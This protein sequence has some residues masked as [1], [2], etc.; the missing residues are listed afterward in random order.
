[1]NYLRMTIREF[2]EEFQVF[3]LKRQR[4]GGFATDMAAA[5]FSW[6]VSKAAKPLFNGSY[7][8]CVKFIHSEGA[9]FM[10]EH[11]IKC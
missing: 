2:N 8:D 6:F 11:G 7:G 10:S 3:K 5:R 9:M 4:D 1:M